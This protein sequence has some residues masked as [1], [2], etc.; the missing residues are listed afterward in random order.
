MVGE[1]S[2]QIRDYNR[3]NT[4]LRD[5]LLRNGKDDLLPIITSPDVSFHFVIQPSSGNRGTADAVSRVVPMIAEGESAVVMGGDDCIYNPDRSEVKR[6][7]DAATE[8]GGSA[9]SGVRVER[10]KLSMYGVIETD[11]AGI[12]SAFTKNRLSKMQRVI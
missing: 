3:I 6:L 11:A 5:Y 12:L 8:Q 4:D 2:T 7:V 9:I 1:Q 10:E